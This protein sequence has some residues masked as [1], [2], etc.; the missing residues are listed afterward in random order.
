[1]QWL[2]VLG[3]ILIL[4][5]F[6]LLQRG[7]VGATSYTY[8]S[9]NTLG[10]V[11]LCITALEERQWGFVLLEVVWLGTC[12]AALFGRLW[13]GRTSPALATPAAEL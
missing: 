11:A 1:M 13:R 12:A 5:A 7:R 4:A 6:V 3:S 9:L 2:Q 8:L 10:A